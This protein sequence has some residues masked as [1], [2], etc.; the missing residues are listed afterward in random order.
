MD[1]GERASIMRCSSVVERQLLELHVGGS[2]PPV[3]TFKPQQ[4]EI[5]FFGR[6]LRRDRSSYA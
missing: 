5:R 3:A 2:S 6:D 1:G 4:H